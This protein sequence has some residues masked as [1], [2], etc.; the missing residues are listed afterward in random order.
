MG[1]VNKRQRKF[2]SKKVLPHRKKGGVRRD[3]SKTNKGGRED[4]TAPAVGEEQQ[5]RKT[6]PDGLDTATFLECDW[7]S[8]DACAVAGRDACVAPFE[9]DAALLEGT[10]GAHGKRGKSSNR[11]GGLTGETARSLVGRAIDDASIDDLFRAVWALQAAASTAPPS[12]SPATGHALLRAE[13]AS[14]AAGILRTEAFSRL[15]QAFRAHLGPER[16]EGDSAEEWE[17]AVRAHR[18][19][20]ERAEAWPELGGALLS[21]LTTALDHTEAQAETLIPATAVA[22]SSSSSG[23]KSGRASAAPLVE[24]LVRMKDHVPLLFPFPRLARRYLVFLLSVLERSDDT[25]TLSVAF[26]RVYELAT[27]QP[28]PFLHDTFKGCY[29]CYRAAADRIGA[30]GKGAAGAKAG[31]GSGGAGSLPLLRECIAELFGVEKPSAY[32]VRNLGWF[33]RV[34]GCTGK[35]VALIKQPRVPLVLHYMN[36]RATKHSCVVDLRGDRCMDICVV[37]GSR[38]VVS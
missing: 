5:Q 19:Q 22:S 23:N 32:L 26:V 13:P 37:S 20:L 11:S 14:E 31:A 35:C 29:R 34:R 10:T 17:D 15:H 24:G 1:K 18:Q 3:K 6:L 16:D 21:F 2:L 30:R 8:R 28:M 4:A 27:S 7:L 33:A 38:T 9:P 25:P 36:G 12:S